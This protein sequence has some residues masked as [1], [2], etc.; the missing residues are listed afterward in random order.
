M[1]GNRFRLLA[2]ELFLLRKRVST[3]VLL[4]IWG[5]L[6]LTFGYIVRYVTYTGSD[7]R[8]GPAGDAM[9]E[10]M[11]PHRL[12]ATM[13]DG[14]PFYGG[15]IAL[16]LGVLSVGSEFGWDTLKTLFTQ[17]P[18]RDRVFAAKMGALAIML[19]PFVVI[20][21]TLGSAASAFIAWREGVAIT[22]PDVSTIVQGM[23][24]GWLVLAV[25]AAVGV[26]LA[27]A[28]RGTSLAIGIGI[29]Y[30]LVIEGLISALA[31]QIDLVE[32]VVQA[33][34]RANAYS[35]LRPLGGSGDVSGNSA[36]TDG[37]GAFSGPYVN[38]MQALAVLVVYVA[39]FLGISLWL[40]RRR[41]VA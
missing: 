27:V 15:A 34:V 13:L 22:W 16:M 2:A 11:L 26:V 23:L 33:F 31:S 9:L 20:V 38:E 40:L 19:V 10:G 28:T 37:P 12:V 39:V 5:T 4:G 36:A 3:W 30:T 21:F 8:D 32:P 1:F 25:W 7:T 29:L 6:G 17:G 24:A 35:L 41:D 18:G 14:F